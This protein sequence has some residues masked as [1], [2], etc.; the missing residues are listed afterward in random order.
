MLDINHVSYAYDTFEALRDVSLTTEEGEIICL[1]GAS[2]CGKTTLL[3]VIAGLETGYSGQISLAGHDLRNTPVN[4]R[5]FGLMF[6]DFALFPHMSVEQNVAYG[7]K[8]QKVPQQEIQRRVQDMLARVGL[9]GFD[10]RDVNLLSGGQKQRV[11]LARSLAPNPRVLML[12][13]PLGSLDALLR[14]QLI[15][16]LR[17]IIK[18]VGL[19]AIYVT[20]DQKEAYAIADRVAV[21]NEG[22]IEQIDT[23][24]NLYYAP[25]TEFV[26]RFLGLSNIFKLDTG[27][28]I[29]R[30]LISSATYDYSSTTAFLI[31]P[32]GIYLDSPI[33]R[34]FVEFSGQ[35]EQII[36][37]GEYHQIA[38]RIAD[39][40]ILYTTTRK[41]NIATGEP[42]KVF[43]VTE[44]TLPLN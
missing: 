15:I 32:S 5:D 1:L 9:S 7:L 28:M 34:P 23:P 37:R 38:V 22:Q 44:L 40:M 11:A 8:R 18:S 21:M 30:R 27:D 29:H 14:D 25:R 24:Q 26:A 35:V 33:D 12:D 13:E 42:L 41:S 31:H 43:V 36:F 17:D 3:R 16:E 39:D 20:H 10:K 4:E 6:Q 19:T 2:G